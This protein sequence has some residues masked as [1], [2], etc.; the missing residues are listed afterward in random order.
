MGEPVFPSATRRAGT[1][2]QDV[3]IN[4]NTHLNFS[5][6]LPGE[7]PIV[8]RLLNGSRLGVSTLAD[9]ESRSA[10][11]LRSIVGVLFAESVLPVVVLSPL[12][13]ELSREIVLNEVAAE[14]DGPKRVDA[15]EIADEAEGLARE[16]GILRDVAVAVDLAEMLL[17]LD[18][19]S[20][21]LF[22]CKQKHQ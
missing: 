3:F 4:S 1:G 14:I 12:V 5:S 9:G 13:G 16:L 2:R 22:L 19:I 11:R 15:D 17:P 8:P 6:G 18:S 10:G 20:L 7:F 21:L